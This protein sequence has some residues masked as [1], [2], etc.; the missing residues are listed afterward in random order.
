M[1]R[2]EPIALGPAR[3]ALTQPPPWAGP[4]RERPGRAGACLA[5]LERAQVRWQ[6]VA[7]PDGH[8]A[9]PGPEA[10]AAL[11][12]GALQPLLAGLAAP[13]PGPDE[14]AC[15]RRLEEALAFAADFPGVSCAACA[16]QRAAGE[17]DPDCAACPRPPVEPFVEQVLSLHRLLGQLPPAAAGLAPSLWGRLPPERARLLAAGLALVG[18]FLAR[19]RALASGAGP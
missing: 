15:L 16:E 4:D 8:E 18:R 19:R 2:P 13:W 10:L 7:W 9:V 5:L 12:A 1:K 3:L 17:A 14:A 6:G 11:P